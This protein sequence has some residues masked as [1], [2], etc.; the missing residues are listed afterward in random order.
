MDSGTGIHLCQASKQNTTVSGNATAS[1]CTG[2]KKVVTMHA[3]STQRFYSLCKYTAVCLRPRSCC[4]HVCGASVVLRGAMCCIRSRFDS[5]ARLCV[6][7]CL[8]LSLSVP[9]FLCFSFPSL[10]IAL[11]LP[12]SL[13]LPFPPYVSRFPSLTPS[14]LDKTKNEPHDQGRP[15]VP[16]RLLLGPP[17]RGDSLPQHPAPHGHQAHAAGLRVQREALQASGRRYPPLRVKINLVCIP[18]PP[19]PF[20]VLGARHMGGFGLGYPRELGR[21][22]VVRGMGALAPGVR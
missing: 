16:L 4:F 14:L 22:A 15:A 13:L 6:R 5:R 3:P 11:S 7:L 12:P 10:S 20:R 1:S 18:S 2:R 21:L 19:L 8:L 17:F 9:V